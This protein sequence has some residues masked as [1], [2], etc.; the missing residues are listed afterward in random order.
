MGMKSKEDLAK[1]D[2]KKKNT[3]DAKKTK[4][5]ALAAKKKRNA[6]DKKAEEPVTVDITAPIA[7][8]EEEAAPKKKAIP[9]SK[10]YIAARALV[11]KT[12]N[13]PVDEA[14]ALVRKTS[15]AKF[16]VTVEAHLVLRDEG[17]NVDV[18]F[19]FTTGQS[20]TVAIATDELLAEIAKGTINF[21]ILIAHPSFMP[22]LAK[23][24][25]VLGPKGLM[26]NPKNG[27]ITPDP[28]KRK[29]ELE[30]GAMTIKGEKKAPL[31]H[32]VLGK[33]S[34]PDKELAANLRALFS[35][36]APGKLLKC[37]VSASMGPGIKVA[38]E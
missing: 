1:R 10:R 24:A 4:A 13:Y 31:A 27:T 9:R 11:D 19:P 15:Y 2:A 3:G 16:P 18:A 34:Q 35:A 28:E 7:D 14:I 8:I 29:K 33:L 21:N 25:R 23:L 5:A 37:T 17:M 12:S 22:K 36:F 26:P 30:G 20:V 38:L 32:V 6:P